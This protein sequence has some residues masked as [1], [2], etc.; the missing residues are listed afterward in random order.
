MQIG[1]RIFLPNS[2]Q[3]IHSEKTEVRC[4]EEEQKFVHSLELFQV[5]M[6]PPFK[7]HISFSC[8]VH[9]KSFLFPFHDIIL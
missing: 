4:S 8:S 5:R 2:V 1:D 9:D 3:E 6:F 7:W